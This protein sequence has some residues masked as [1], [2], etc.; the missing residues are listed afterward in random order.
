MAKEQPS[1]PDPARALDLLWGTAPVPKRGPKQRLS[2]EAITTAAIAIADADGLEALSMRRVADALGVGT[3]TL[4]TYVPAKG[5]LI[6]LM[7]DAVAGEVAGRTPAPADAPDWRT[8]LRQVAQDNWDAIHRHPWILQVTSARPA[9]GPLTIAKYDRELA[10]FD[11]IGLTDI[12]IDASLTLLL[13]HVEGAARSATD[14]ALAE[15]RTGISELEWWEAVSPVLERHFDPARFPFAARI[16]EAAGAAN[17]SVTA[18]DH[19][20]AFGLERILDGIAALIAL[21]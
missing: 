9:L 14:A 1:R 12:Q 17:Q 5:E 19:G 15:Q 11:G 7:R 6:D 13:N 2:A 10:A 4:Y 3:M 8:G 21:P 16:G 20:F 18:P